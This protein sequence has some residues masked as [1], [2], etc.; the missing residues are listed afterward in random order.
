MTRE[1]SFIGLDDPPFH[2]RGENAQGAVDGFLRWRWVL[3]LERGPDVTGFVVGLGGQEVVEDAGLATSVL[4]VGDDVA[5]SR[6][7][8]DACFHCR[9]LWFVVSNVLCLFRIG[10]A[11]FLSTG[12]V[13]APVSTLDSWAELVSISKPAAVELGVFPEAYW[14]VIPFVRE[15][16][17]LA[18][19]TGKVC[20]LVCGENVFFLL[21]QDDR[22]C[23]FILS[24]RMTE[25][26][27]SAVFCQMRMRYHCFTCLVNPLTLSRLGTG[28]LVRC[29]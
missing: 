5:D 20:L 21:D 1:R 11:R 24:V 27:H 8:F 16:S 17:W 29:H 23:L 19:R 3:V 7:G 28:A 10:R 22:L 25:E 18:S 9:G 14:F 6:R 13:E 15:I 4:D 26:M 2:V 12:G